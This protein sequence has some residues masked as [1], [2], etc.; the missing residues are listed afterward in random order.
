MRPV[1]EGPKHRAFV[2]GPFSL[3]VLLVASCGGDAQTDGSTQAVQNGP[4]S[5][6]SSTASAAQ[7]CPTYEDDFLPRIN[8]PVCSHCHGL[9]PRLP[10]WGVYSQASA[11]CT[12][13]GSSVA[14][15]SM[16]P[17]G[18][19]LSLSADQQALVAEWVQLGCPET[20]AALPNSCNGGSP[21]M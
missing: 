21:G 6:P 10:N 4:G 2:F 17:R 13:I 5:A 20:A 1:H 15:G 18:S 11:A 3:V 14:Q 9:Q 16:P 7:S 8:A 19:G 12:R